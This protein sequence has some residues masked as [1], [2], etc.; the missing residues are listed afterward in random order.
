VFLSLALRRVVTTR[1]PLTTVSTMLRRRWVERIASRDRVRVDGVGDVE[2]LLW[3]RGRRIA[4][5]GLSG[6]R[7]GVVVHR[8]IWWSAWAHGNVKMWKGEYSLIS[9][10]P[11]IMPQSRGSKAKS[12]LSRRRRKEA[13]S[14]RGNET[15]R[16]WLAPHISYKLNL[17]TSKEPR[18]EPQLGLA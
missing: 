10:C 11:K 17:G 6:Q 2:R 1:Q 14:M 12:E 13:S 3:L 8:A 4:W 18:P 5:I 15:E 7:L 9:Q 16:E